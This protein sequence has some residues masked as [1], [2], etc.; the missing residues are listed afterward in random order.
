VK[1]D[2]NKAAHELSRFATRNS[3]PYVWLEEPPNCILNT[4][5][6]EQKALFL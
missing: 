3:D 6:L 4:V 2:A 5:I 1:R